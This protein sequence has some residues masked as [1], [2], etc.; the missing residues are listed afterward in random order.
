MVDLKIDGRK[1][2]LETRFE[3]FVL[4]LR[5]LLW[6][7]KNVLSRARFNL[8]YIEKYY[9][10]VERVIEIFFKTLNSKSLWSKMLEEELYFVSYFIRTYVRT[11]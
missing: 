11:K 9:E 4:C 5:R 2:F 7:S 1:V 10:H 8:N 3:H 6:W